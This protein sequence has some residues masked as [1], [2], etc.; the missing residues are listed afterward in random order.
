MI[1][2]VSLYYPPSSNPPANRMGCLVRALVDRHGAQNVR[3]VTGRPNYPDG[4]LLPEHRWKLFVRSKGEYGETVDHVYEYPA[5]F[6]GLYRKTFG[7][8]TFALSL[9]VYFLFRRIRSNDVILVT[10]GPVFSIYSFLALS[11][12]KRKMRYIVDVRDLW[13]QV[14]AGMG[15]MKETSVPYR[16]LLKLAEATY[17]RAAA[18]VGNSPGICDYLRKTAPGK[19]VSLVF[20]PVDTALFVKVSD[21]ERRRF[22]EA[23][24]DVFPADGRPVFL[25]YG[26]FSNYIGL[27]DLF[28]AWAA[29]KKITGN[30]RFVMI[31]QG[32][33]EAGMRRCIAENNLDDQVMILPFMERPELVQY[34]GAADFCFAS[35]RQSKM[36]EYAIPTKVIEYLACDKEVVAVVGGAFGKMLE[37]HD[38]AYVSPPGDVERLVRLLAALIEKWPHVPAEHHPRSFVESRFGIAVFERGFTELLQPL[39]QQRPRD[40]AANALKG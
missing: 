39:L 7:Q 5:P 21:E 29:L 6:K 15:F 2:I 31:G 9:F 36:L 18:L 30:F 22:R 24:P 8:L 14:V 33:G 10:S 20:N 11:Y 1:Y 4:K 37:Q 12:L 35:L 13:P 40:A 16:L 26:T 32:E 19:P 28:K 17:R 25:F 27:N 23:H 34:V 38:A 3:V